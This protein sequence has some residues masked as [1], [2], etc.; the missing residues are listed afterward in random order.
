M[1]YAMPFL[2][3]HAAGALWESGGR[4]PAHFGNFSAVKSSPPEAIPACASRAPPPSV[5]GCDSNVGA[6]IARPLGCDA[7]V[8]R[9]TQ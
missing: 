6:R 1:A 3:M 5:P 7:R 2:G 8:P 9:R 4:S